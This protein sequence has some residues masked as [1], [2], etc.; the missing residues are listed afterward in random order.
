[1]QE[2]QEYCSGLPIPSL[3]DLPDL[4]IELGSPALQVGSFPTELSEKPSRDP[5]SKADS[6]RKHTAN[7]ELP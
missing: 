2:A 4:G 6:S 3:E 7:S 5:S 1:M